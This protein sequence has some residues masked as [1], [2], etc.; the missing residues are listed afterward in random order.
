M[1]Q[2]CTTAMK[3]AKKIQKIWFKS[4]KKSDFFSIFYQKSWFFPTLEL[5]LSFDVNQYYAHF[6]TSCSAL[7]E[8]VVLGSTLC[9]LLC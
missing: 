4:K 8:V 6:I 3:N 2:Q 9:S 5:P 1:Q 7:A